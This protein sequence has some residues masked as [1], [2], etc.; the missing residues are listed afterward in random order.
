MTVTMHYYQKCP[1]CGRKLRV[2]QQWSGQ[3]V[4]CSHCAMEFRTHS[5]DVN[6]VAEVR[7]AQSAAPAFDNGA[8]S[9]DVRDAKPVNQSV[10]L[11]DDDRAVL[12]S[13]A[14]ALNRCGMIVTAVHHPR[15][16]MAA[17]RVHPYAVAILDNGLTEMNGIELMESLIAYLPELRV[18]ILSGSNDSELKRRAKNAGAFAFLEKPC[19]LD[20][21]RT[22]VKEALSSGK[23][24][25]NAANVNQEEQPVHLNERSDRH[26]VLQPT[27][28][29]TAV[30]T[31]GRILG[32]DE[33]DSV[34]HQSESY[35]V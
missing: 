24:F 1:C 9:T 15:M 21:L 26:N 2:E 18:I 5:S 16:A 35:D 22:T 11:V 10:L 28:S 14:T 27:G 13:F 3:N 25:S 17:I 19:R 8:G 29:S 34:E 30:S 12:D 31:I 20:L 33:R 23:P 7:I 4:R 6:N 32:D